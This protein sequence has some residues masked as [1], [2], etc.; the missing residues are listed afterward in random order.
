M[1]V[2]LENF[3]LHVIHVVFAELKH[4]VT[5]G[6]GKLKTALDVAFFGL[7]VRTPYVFKVF[8]CIFTLEQVTEDQLVF[9]YRL[10]RND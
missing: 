3:N 9:I 5:K 1:V 6:I 10:F 4:S 2:G 8:F 7:L